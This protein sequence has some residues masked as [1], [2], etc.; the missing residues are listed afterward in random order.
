[1]STSTWKVT[2]NRASTASMRAWSTPG[3][4]SL[5]IRKGHFY[6]ALIG[7]VLA[8]EPQV[9]D[10]GAVGLLGADY[11]DVLAAAARAARPSNPPCANRCK[12]AGP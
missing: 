11:G 6:P 5:L 4:P 12:Q 9:T 10:E 8:T 1:M 2:E 3:K 7:D